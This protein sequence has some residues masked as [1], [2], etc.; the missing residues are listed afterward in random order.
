MAQGNPKEIEP[1][2]KYPRWLVEVNRGKVAS[3]SYAACPSVG[4]LPSHIQCT[5]CRWT[6]VRNSNLDRE[7]ELLMYL[8]FRRQCPF[9]VEPRP[10][11]APHLMQPRPSKGHPSL[12]RWTERGTWTG[13]C[14]SA[15]V[16][17]RSWV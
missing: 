6:G 15:R 2:I 16:K 8:T 5:T 7:E 1:A 13:F 11:T 4:T 12:E 9:P 17:S 14:C 10:S 3:S